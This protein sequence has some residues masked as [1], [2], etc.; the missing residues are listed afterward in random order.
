MSTSFLTSLFSVGLSLARAG[1][2]ALVDGALNTVSEWWRS[3]LRTDLIAIVSRAAHL[4]ITAV[5]PVVGLHVANA[6]SSIRRRNGGTLSPARLFDNPP[7]PPLPARAVQ[8]GGSSSALSPSLSV[9]GTSPGLVD[10]TPVTRC[11]NTIPSLVVALRMP[12]HT[13]GTEYPSQSGTSQHMLNY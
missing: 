3:G 1:L 10:V 13:I 12:S 11:Q 2:S 7:H 8:S 4:L 9:A 6:P 5:S